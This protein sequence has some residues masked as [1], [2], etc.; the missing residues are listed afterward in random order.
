[1]P[2]LHVQQYGWI[3]CNHCISYVTTALLHETL[4]YIEKHGKHID[5]HW[6]TP[7][8]DSFAEDMTALPFWTTET[9]ATP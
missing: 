1:M 7:D 4:V 9:G 8:N 2:W 6:S 3:R 5:A